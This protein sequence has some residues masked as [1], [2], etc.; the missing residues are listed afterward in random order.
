MAKNEID[1]QIS[2]LFRFNSHKTTKQKIRLLESSKYFQ[3]DVFDLRKKYPKVVNEY[4]VNF[5]N[6]SKKLCEEIF[7]KNNLENEIKNKAKNEE[8]ALKLLS[9]SIKKISKENIEKEYKKLALETVKPLKDKSFNKDIIEICE[10]YKL[11]PI[12]NWLYSIMVYVVFDQLPPP[13]FLLGAGLDGYLS[14]DEIVRL[15]QDLNFSLKIETNKTT[16]EKELFIKVFDNTTL[17]DDL[18]KHWHIIEK[19]QKILR[20]EKGIKRYHVIKNLPIMEKLSKK[21]ET[22]IYDA[23]LGRE[24]KINDIDRALE[25]YEDIPFDKKEEKKA[26]NRIKQIRHRHKKKLF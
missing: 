2:D 3:N 21:E 20:K 13:D 1:K 18:R 22:M 15:P 17:K 23:V 5:S 19:M 24:V 26:G 4:R 9:L 6:L 12:E 10:R 25:I 8:Q 14:R 11:Y 7:L 16:K